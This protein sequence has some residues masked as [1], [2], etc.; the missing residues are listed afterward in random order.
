M[1]TGRGSLTRRCPRRVAGVESVRDSYLGGR[2]SVDRRD[3]DVMAAGRLVDPVEDERH[4]IRRDLGMVIVESSSAVRRAGEGELTT[5]GA[6]DTDRPD[7]SLEVRF[8]AGCHEHEN[9]LPIRGPSHLVEERARLRT[10][11]IHCALMRSIRV[12]EHEDVA[13]VTATRSIEGDLTSVGRDCRR[14]DAEPAVRDLHHPRA[15]RPCSPERREWPAP[16]VVV[17]EQEEPRQMGIAFGRGIEDA[18]PTIGGSRTVII[19]SVAV[20]PLVKTP[21][22]LCCLHPPARRMSDFRSM[23]MQPRVIR[24]LPA[25]LHESQQA[26][27]HAHAYSGSR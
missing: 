2:A 16:V 23:N 19:N 5:M 11:G 15:S 9:G 22:R 12:G 25:S 27:S 24:A 7:A 17:Q 8:Y 21:P 14:P 4:P 20:T 1:A 6:I 13:V 26:R 18:C 3:L 10:Q